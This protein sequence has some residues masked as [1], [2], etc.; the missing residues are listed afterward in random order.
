M[1]LCPVIHALYDWG[2]KHRKQIFDLA[3]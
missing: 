1:S 2:T 3:E